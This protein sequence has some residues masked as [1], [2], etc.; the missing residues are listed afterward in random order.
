MKRTLPL[1]LKL[2]YTLMVLFIIPLYWRE[3]GPGNLLWF[4]DIAL[5]VLAI[6]LWAR[7]RLLVSMMVVGTLLLEFAW[8]IGFMTGG[9]LLI[10]GYM[11]DESL[12]LWLRAL[13]GFHFILPPLMIFLLWRWGYDKRALKWQTL[14]AWI[15][16][17][18][19]YLTT[20][21]ESNINWIFGPGIAQDTIP[22]LLWLALIM[23]A[24]PLLIYLP[25]HWV[26]KR[27]FKVRG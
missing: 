3:Y 25:S 21:K 23:I 5:I 10:T 11:F 14:L 18:V 27:L 13:S 8:L 7:S 19:T 16:L 20:D 6:A 15:I 4:S 12:P 26:L 1:W 22:P 2:A 9:K 17:P 24:L